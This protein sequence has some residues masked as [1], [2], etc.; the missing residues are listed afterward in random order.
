MIGFLDST[1]VQHA[2][3]AFHEL[4]KPGGTLFLKSTYIGPLSVEVGSSLE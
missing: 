3:V 4:L 1:Q 2:F